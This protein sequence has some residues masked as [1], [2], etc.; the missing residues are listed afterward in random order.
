VEAIAATS[1]T[2]Q[3]CTTFGVAKA[4]SAPSPPSALMSARSATTTNMSPVSA[5][6][7]EPTM[8]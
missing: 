3:K 2:A 6:A 7:D 4:L 5:A 1:S 8:T